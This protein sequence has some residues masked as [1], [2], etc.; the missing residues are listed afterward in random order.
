MDCGDK[1]LLFIVVSSFFCEKVTSSCSRWIDLE[2]I[3]LAADVWRL[4][5]ELRRRELDRPA[6]ARKW[7]QWETA[8][9]CGKFHISIKKNSFPSFLHLRQA[10]T[11]GRATLC[12]WGLSG[13]TPRLEHYSP[14][15]VWHNTC[16][17]NFLFEYPSLTV[18]LNI[19]HFQ[20]A[21]RWSKRKH[22]F[23]LRVFAAFE[24]TSEVKVR[25]VCL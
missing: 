1:M 23:L 22:L 10:W 21:G 20:H 2:I 17:I 18:A 14:G 7:G 4:A 8:Q 19:K 9:F 13:M 3:F 24:N 12:L 11:C 5:A 6:G 16:F 25:N 15:A